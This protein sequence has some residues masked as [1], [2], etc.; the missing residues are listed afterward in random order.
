MRL[1]VGISCGG[2]RG[3]IRCRN[4]TNFQPAKC[5]DNAARTHRQLHAVLGGVS[6]R[7]TLSRKTETAARLAIL[8]HASLLLSTDKNHNLPG[9]WIFKDQLRPKNNLAN[10]TNI[11]IE[12]LGKSK[13][14]T[15]A[16]IGSLQDIHTFQEEAFVVQKE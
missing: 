4:G 2:W 3:E 1:T 15:A 7:K 12:T 13:T 10:A 11:T 8:L 5:Q 14:R 16:T 9:Q 6:E